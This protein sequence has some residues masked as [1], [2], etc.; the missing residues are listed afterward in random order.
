MATEGAILAALVTELRDLTG[1]HPYLA[2]EPEMASPFAFFL[3][4]QDLA[5]DW[6]QGDGP[7]TGECVVGTDWTQGVSGAGA[8]TLLDY[9]NSEGAKSVVVKLNGNK[10]NGLLVAGI[11]VQQRTRW[12]VHRF[13]DGRTYL[14]RP[15]RLKIYV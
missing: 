3:L 4:D 8:R 12:E 10:L 13:P 7:L 2:P 5:I 9:T 1:L 15:I 11:H 6:N 14:A